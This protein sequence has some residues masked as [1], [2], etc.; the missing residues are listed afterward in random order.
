MRETRNGGAREA[1]YTRTQ[2]AI[3]QQAVKAVW[4]VMKQAGRG[5]VA[6]VADCARG[7]DLNRL[8]NTSSAAQFAALSHGQQN[9]L[10]DR[11]YRP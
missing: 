6:M 1:T 11:G 8:F 4:A 3:D 9:R 7:D 10:L 5:L 2:I